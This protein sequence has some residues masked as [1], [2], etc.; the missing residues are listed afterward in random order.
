MQNQ[1][2]YLT[3]GEFAKLCHTTK[4]TLFHYCDI[5]LFE[6]AYTDEN[7]YRY[8]HVLQY[9]TFMA[10]S[11]LRAMGMSLKEIREYLAERS[12]ERMAELYK[13]QE[14]LIDEKIAELNRIKNH[15]RSQKEKIN[16]VIK[17][18]HEYF[19]ETQEQCTLS[20]SQW[21]TQRDDYS[22][23]S[24]IG[25]LM[26][27]NDDM[28]SSGMVCRLEDSLQSENYPFC[29]YVRSSPE[30]T[31]DIHIKKSGSYLCTYHY[32]DYEA[33]GNTFKKLIRYAGGQGIELD[34]WIYAETIAGDWAVTQP[35]EYII[36][37]SVRITGKKI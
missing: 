22:M 37:V 8:Y 21:I 19:I 9:D 32:G 13:K 16:R 31:E 10:I 36:K 29:F 30:N 15:I 17:G 20:C 27:D 35:Q 25:S 3:T 2:N 26:T 24:S 12:P 18:L 14:Q 34:N 6:P 7:G 5:H 11:E 33:M 28:N 1:K 23:T 4:Y